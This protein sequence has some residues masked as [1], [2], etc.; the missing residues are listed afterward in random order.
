MY[1]N[2]GSRY[3]H[4]DRRPIYVSRPVIRERY[5]NYYRRP[6]LIVEGYGPRPGYFWVAGNWYW[7]GAEWTWQSGHYQPDPNYV[8][9]GYYDSY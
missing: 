1:V 6:T 9:S 7:S 3:R 2:E 5:Y 4:F 8:E